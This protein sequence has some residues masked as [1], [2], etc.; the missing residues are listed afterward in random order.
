MKTLSYLAII[1][2]GLISTNCSDSYY[3]AGLI[4]PMT[5]SGEF[6]DIC[7]IYS[8]KDGFNVYSKP[9]GR[10]IGRI[11]RNTK[12][13]DA[14]ESQYSIYYWNNK[15]D[16]KVQIDL[17]SLA[18]VSYEIWSIKYI[19]RKD[20]FVRIINTNNEMWLSE[21]EIVSSGFGLTSW[22]AF[23]IDNTD[24]LLGFYANDRGLNLMSSPNIDS[25]ILKNL[26]GDTF[27][28]R[29]TNQSHYNWTKVRVTKTKEHPCGTD[30]K[31]EDNFEY[32]IEGWVQLVDKH[33]NPNVWYYPRGC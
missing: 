11:K 32:Q 7:C 2:L 10:R 14:Q 16:K 18:E 5:N 24:I 20:G 27:D 21:K 29:P 25:N 13:T 30:L 1:T 12:S 31:E 9:N 33:G 15:N 6:D 19:D 28:I 23:I 8:P 26:K 22:Q 4:M 3:K 17:N